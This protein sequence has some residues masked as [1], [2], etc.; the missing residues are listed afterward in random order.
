[1]KSYYMKH[2]YGVAA[3]CPRAMLLLDIKEHYFKTG[4]KNKKR[5]IL[6][7]AVSSE[8]GHNISLVLPVV[9]ALTRCDS[10]VRFLG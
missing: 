6:M 8:I 9:H 10:K 2:W 4:V 3:I 1:M 7:P 5:F